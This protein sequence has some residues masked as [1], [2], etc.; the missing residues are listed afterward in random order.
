M[1][2]N[3]KNHLRFNP[4]HH[5]IL[6]PLSFFLL[7]TAAVHFVKSDKIIGSSEFILLLGAILIVMLGFVARLYALKLQDRMIRV[8]MRQRYY[9]L[10]GKSFREMENKL[11]LGQIIALRFAGDEELLPLMER[12]ISE[13]MSNKDIKK[14]VNNW[15]ADNLRC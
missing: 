14:A 1:A 11:S 8:E 2:Q 9:E 3:Y 15:Q 5:F 10:T 7:I 13:S 12:A 4:L 6:V